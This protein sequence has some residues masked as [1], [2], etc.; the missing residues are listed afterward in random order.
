MKVTVAASEGHRAHLG[1]GWAVDFFSDY[2]LVIAVLAFVI[3]ARVWL[4]RRYP[5]SRWLL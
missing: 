4:R 3:A 1:V 5:S 2:A